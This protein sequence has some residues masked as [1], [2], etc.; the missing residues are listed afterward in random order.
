M[1]GLLVGITL[2]GLVGNKLC[3]N[4]T[5]T[6]LGNPAT[7]LIFVAMQVPLPPSILQPIC[8]PILTP[9]RHAHTAAA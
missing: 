6:G 4:I 8:P 1:M 5:A 3:V 9:I 2:T 7:S